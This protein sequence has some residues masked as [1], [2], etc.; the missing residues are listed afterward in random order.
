M[1]FRCECLYGCTDVVGRVASVIKFTSPADAK[2]VT[3]NGGTLIIFL[4]ISSCCILRELHGYTSNLQI[5]RHSSQVNIFETRQIRR[6]QEPQVPLTK[7]SE[8]SNHS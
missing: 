7:A 2:C 8:F 1:D 4:Y 6:S 5:T 3:D